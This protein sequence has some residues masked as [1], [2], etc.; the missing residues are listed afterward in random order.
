M[1]AEVARVLG[2][3][4]DVIVVRKLGVSFQLELG[5]GALGE[6]GVRVLN[7]DVVAGAGVSAGEMAAVE[8]A[9]RALQWL[10]SHL[11]LTAVR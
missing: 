3:P 8:A 11:R 4:L 2:A 6:G 1:A 9:E 7:R 10:T 5:M